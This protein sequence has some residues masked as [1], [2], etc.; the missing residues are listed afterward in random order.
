MKMSAVPAQAISRF[1]VKS[2]ET[3]TNMVYHP[4]SLIRTSASSTAAR[5]TLLQSI[6]VG[7]ALTSVVGIMFLI[8]FF[9]FATPFA[10]LFFFGF[11]LSLFF[12]SGFFF[13]LFSSFFFLASF[14]LE[15]F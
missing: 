11:Y 12:F 3:V 5:D 14:F 2:V 6:G 1:V 15:P 7:V 4:E 8:L 13:A 10:L 9:F